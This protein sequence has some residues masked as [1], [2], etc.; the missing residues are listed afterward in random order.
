MQ[1]SPIDELSFNERDKPGDGKIV[2][3]IIGGLIL[4]LAASI[5]LFNAQE[6]QHARAQDLKL[7]K[8]VAASLGGAAPEDYSGGLLY[9]NRKNPGAQVNADDFM[10]AGKENIF[11]F[12][13]DKCD[14]CTQMT[15]FLERLAEKRKDIS[16]KV[17]DI[18]RP[19]AEEIDFE[20]PVAEQYDIHV[21][22]QFRIYD[23]R[24][25]LSATGDDAKQKIK[26]MMQ[27]CGV[28]Q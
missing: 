7:R 9:V 14:P 24:Q 26:H 11:Y 27:E 25:M 2:L 20:S 5:C 12:H 17:I 28:A 15:P 19:D 16:I 23:S 18:D 21:V 4:L 22:P 8:G 3:A 1:N 10:V 13:S 6:M